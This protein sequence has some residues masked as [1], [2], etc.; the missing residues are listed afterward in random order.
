MVHEAG[1]VLWTPKPVLHVIIRLKV[2]TKVQVL[3]AVADDDAMLFHQVIV[4]LA[5][6]TLMGVI[7]MYPHILQTLTGNVSQPVLGDECRLTGYSALRIDERENS[8]RIG[9]VIGYCE[10]YVATCQNGRCGPSL[11]ERAEH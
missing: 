4:V 11:T 5:G 8:V 7:M 6:R 9:C 3:T 1:V 2:G 10:V